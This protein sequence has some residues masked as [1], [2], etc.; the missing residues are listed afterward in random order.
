M[1]YG[2][3][4][5][6]RSLQTTWYV[7]LYQQQIKCT[8]TQRGNFKS[9]PH[10]ATKKISLC[11]YIMKILSWQSRLRIEQ[12]VISSELIKHC[13]HT[14]RIE[15][16]KS[17]FEVLDNECLDKLVKVMTKS[18]ITIQ[19]VPPHLH[20]ANVE[21]R[22]IHTW[23]NN[24]IAMLFGLEPRFLIQ[25]WDRLVDQTNLTLNPLRQARSNP[26]MAA[27]TMINGPFDFNQTPIN[28]L[29]TKCLVHEKPVVRGTWAPHTIDDWYI[30]PERKHYICYSV[31]IP[32]T[33]G[34][35]TSEAAWVF[36]D[37]LAIPKVFLKIQ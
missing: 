16:Y 24:F 37:H 3:Q 19:L 23:K 30:D 17:N 31:Y 26:R 25:L 7:L 20:R 12:Q 5:I 10:L 9:N 33:R 8:Q 1:T 15:G 28:P 36:P 6:L 21:E 34:T 27:P 18:K 22:E 35:K 4:R 11:M 14:S 13:I 29:G 32:S 2:S